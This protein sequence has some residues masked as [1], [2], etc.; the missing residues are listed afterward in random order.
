MIFVAGG[1]LAGLSWLLISLLLCVRVVPLCIAVDNITCIRV[2]AVLLP[3]SGARVLSEVE[4]MCVGDG[5]SVKGVLG[6]GGE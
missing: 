4:G 1:C 3:F 5:M 2:D 6:C